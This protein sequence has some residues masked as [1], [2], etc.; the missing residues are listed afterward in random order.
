MEAL[1][2]LS[3][4][5]LGETEVDKFDKVSVPVGK[6]YILRLQVSVHDVQT[7][8]VG[9]GLKALTDNFGRLGFGE[10]FASLGLNFTACKK[11]GDQVQVLVIH[12]DLV[13]LYDVWMI[14]GKKDAQLLLQIIFLFPNDTLALDRLDRKVFA[15]INSFICDSHRA[16]RTGAQTLRECVD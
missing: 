14:S 12:V 6:E 2:G 16:I 3:C 4:A 7:V 5:E 11:L 13:E 9:Q 15:G 8:K 10:L 1:F